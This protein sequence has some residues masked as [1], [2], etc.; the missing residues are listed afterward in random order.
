MIQSKKAFTLIEL[1]VVVAIIGVIAV[2]VIG[3]VKRAIF[4]AQAA[5]IINTI[6]LVE[7]VFIIRMLD[8][9][10]STWW[11]EDDFPSTNSWAAYL[12]NLIN[13]ENLIDEFLP[14]APDLPGSEAGNFEFAYDNDGDTFVDPVNPADCNTWSNPSP[15]NSWNSLFGP[16]IVI[17]PDEVPGSERY[18][19]L[20]DYLDAN[21]DG[22]DGPYCGRMR[23]DA[24][25]DDGSTANRHRYMRYGFD[26]N[27]I[28]GDDIGL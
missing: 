24:R 21:I 15:W 13:E 8:D 6:T 23:A 12:E 4:K 20:F 19:D 22:G 14:L 2:I 18:W 27:Q 7:E 16:N 11:H 25:T 9:N 3:S 1:L 28:Y 5:H 26:Y 10:R 17:H